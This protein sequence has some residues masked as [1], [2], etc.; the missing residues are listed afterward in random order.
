LNPSRLEAQSGRKCYSRTA[1]PPHAGGDRAQALAVMK[2]QL[3]LAEGLTAVAST[4]EVEQIRA[5]SHDGIAN[6]LARMGKEKL[7]DALAEY[8]NARVIY[9]K[10]AAAHPIIPSSSATIG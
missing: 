3:D 9:E 7:K 2:E 6:V 8:E 10:L 1:A 4:D 5:K